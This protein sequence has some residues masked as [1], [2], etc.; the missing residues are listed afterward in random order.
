MAHFGLWVSGHSFKK[1]RRELNK[2]NKSKALATPKNM[3]GVPKSK[4]WAV[5]KDKD[6]RRT[7]KDPVTFNEVSR[8]VASP[9]GLSL[10]H[11]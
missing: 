8:G 2:A 3:K 5:D 6:M 1:N 4:R 10:I 11:I 7:G 9:R